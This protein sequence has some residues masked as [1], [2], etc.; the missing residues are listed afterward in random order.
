[1]LGFVASYI[2]D[3]TVLYMFPGA[4]QVPASG[5]V[6]AV[7]TSTHG[8]TQGPSRLQLLGGL[9]RTEWAAQGSRRRTRT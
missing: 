6:T 1:M 5:P 7:L 3:L 8:G 4:D 9:C 2:R